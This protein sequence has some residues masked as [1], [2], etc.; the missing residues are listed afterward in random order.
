M[1]R[2]KGYRLISI[3]VMNDIDYASIDGKLLR[4]FLVV[5]EERSATRAASRL[6]VTQSTVSHSLGRLR[7]LIGDPL[8]IRSGQ[9]LVPTEVALSLQ[10]P[11]RSILDE[12][13][14]LTYRRTFDPARESLRFILAANDMQ[15]DL[16]FPRLVRELL[17][18]K[19]AV[20]FEFSPSGHPT[21]DMMRAE[22][23]HLALTP[24]PPEASDIMQKPV[25]SAKMMCFFDRATREAP[26]TWQ[27]Y[28]EADHLTVRFPD[29][30]TSLRALRGVDTS[31]IRRP[32]ISVPNF[33]AIPQFVKGTGLIATEM[34]LMKL[35]TLSDLEMAPLPVDSAPVTIYMAW[36]Q[37][38]TNDPA[39]I[40]LRQRIGA[41]AADVMQGMPQ[42]G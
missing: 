1:N 41:I 42:P 14:A 21:A 15:R 34:G 5:L 26:E 3:E 37:R 19:V 31:G 35:S 11:V 6:G 10:R 36:H 28:C 24:F 39:H 20:E 29:G 16:I 2:Q 40:W 25:L 8:F 7:R 33:G 4:T 23:C 32:M 38:S 13:K 27:E 17:S 9:A 18:E 22:R 12:M 30:G